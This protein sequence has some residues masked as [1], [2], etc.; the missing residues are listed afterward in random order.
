MRSFNSYAKILCPTHGEIVLNWDEFK[1]QSHYLL[2]LQGHRIFWCNICGA[3]AYFNDRYDSKPI[4]LRNNSHL[5]FQT[6]S[7]KYSHHFYSSIWRMI[8]D[9]RDINEKTNGV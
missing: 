9:S 4:S 2:A 8:N 3:I 5:F 6:N 7:H 1:I